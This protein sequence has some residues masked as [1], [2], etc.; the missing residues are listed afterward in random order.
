MFISAGVE[1][2]SRF[3]KGTLD[4]WPD[5]HNHQFD[6]ANARTDEGRRGWRRR[7]VA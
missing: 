5:T 2:V 4:H 6:D 1:T 3:A 7:Q